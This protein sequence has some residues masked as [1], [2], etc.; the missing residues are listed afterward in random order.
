MITYFGIPAKIIAEAL[1]ARRVPSFDGGKWKVGA[2]GKLEVDANGNPVWINSAGVEQS[3]AGDTITRLNGEAQGHRTAKE[4]AEAK[5]KAYA[6]NGIGDPVEIKKILDKYKDVDLTKMIDAGK[7]EEVKAQITSTMQAA[8]DE[9]NK[10]GDGYRDKLHGN[11][12][13]SAFAGSKWAKDNLTI[14]PEMAQS[15]F[16]SRFKIDDND[17]VIFVGADGKTQA[18]S[19]K[20]AGEFATFDEGLEALVTGYAGKDTILKG[21]NNRGSGNGGNG[22]NQPGGKRTIARA[23]FDKL[24]ETEKASLGKQAGPGGTV[25]ITD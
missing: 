4:A 12:L 19:T 17:N 20:R 6:D 2:D 11:L 13:S 24:P 25:V 16:G 5:L 10:R 15:F 21:S 18:M 7:L 23:E 14:P 9:A 8:I 3:V 1:R 22:G